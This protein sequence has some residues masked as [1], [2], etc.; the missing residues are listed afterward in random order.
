MEVHMNSKIFT[1]IVAG[2]IAGVVFGLMM[3]MT[4]A[5][6][7]NGDSMPMMAMVAM[8][9]G[10]KSI[11]AGW[12]YHLFNSALIGGIFGW[13]FGNRIHSYAQGLGLGAV[14]GA[15]WWVLGA[16]ILMPIF[17]GMSAFTPLMMAPMRMVA[18]GSLVGHL[19]FGLILGG[20]YLL[21]HHEG[22]AEPHPS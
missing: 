22:S 8:V 2:L 12:A 13:L 14:Y 17:L 4:A 21:L 10:A 6:T 1:G 9:V 11:A 20:G 3:T 16:L 5:P 7:P 18:V 19:M 15:I